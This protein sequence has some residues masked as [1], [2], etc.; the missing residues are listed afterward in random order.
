[1]RTNYC[2]EIRENNI[3]AEVTL[4]GWVHR[5]RDHGGVVFIDLRDRSGVVQLVFNPETDAE[6]VKAAQ[7]IR[8]EFVL[9]I[10]GE[11]SKRPP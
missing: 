10:K 4:A 2:G 6:I 11:V 7:K 9:Q 3:G 8:N 1:M 5:W